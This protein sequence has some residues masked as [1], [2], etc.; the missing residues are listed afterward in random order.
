MICGKYTWRAG[1]DG[2]VPSMSLPLSLLPSSLLQQYVYTFYLYKCSRG[3][4]YTLT[5]QIGEH[6]TEILHA[7]SITISSQPQYTL[8]LHCWC[9]IY[10][11]LLVHN[12]GA[13]IH[14]WCFCWKTTLNIFLAPESTH[15]HVVVWVHNVLAIYIYVDKNNSGEW[16]T[17]D[18]AT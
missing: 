12:T 15:R 8:Y 16:V 18:K 17:K 11:P 1:S 9:T 13:G 2:G 5:L 3:R 14:M 7:G 4:Y 10:I 6:S